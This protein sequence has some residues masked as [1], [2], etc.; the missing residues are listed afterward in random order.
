MCI[1]FK[2]CSYFFKCY[3][4]KFTKKVVEVFHH[5][6]DKFKNRLNEGIS[7]LSNKFEAYILSFFFFF[8]NAVKEHRKFYTIYET[9]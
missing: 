6:I 3:F 1:V 9:R 4:L 5:Q 8:R 2:M 7:D